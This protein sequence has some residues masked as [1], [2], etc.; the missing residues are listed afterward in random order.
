MTQ[1]RQPEPRDG[2]TTGS[3]AAA[4]T[5]A[6]LAVL[7]AGEMSDE[8]TIPLP[9]DEHGVIPPERITVPLS[10]CERV[11][12]RNALMGYAGVIKN[13]GD[14]PDVTDGLLITAHVARDP[15]QFPPE[16]LRDSRAPLALGNGITLYAGRG[17]GVATLPGLPV[18]VGEIAVNPSPRRQIAASLL[19]VAG[20][21]GYH[22]NIHCRLSALDGETRAKKTLNPRLGIVGGISILGTRGTVKAFSAEAWRV[23]ISRALD[24]AA[25]SGCSTVCLSTG[26][27]SE[28]ALRAMF[29]DLPE[30]AFIQAADHAGHALASAAARGFSRIVWGCFPG[31]LLKLAQGL[32]WTHAHAATPDFGLLEQLCA[33]VG[34]KGKSIRDAL[35]IPTVAGALETIRTLSPEGYRA[36]LARMAEMALASARALAAKGGRPGEIVVCAFAAHGELQATAKG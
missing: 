3:A 21:W 19:E 8:I 9:P 35:R 18:A 4:T 26:R 32:A 2:F 5:A 10:F 36:I 16:L 20:L 12:D 30:Q 17:I 23:T 25:E 29:S 15:A 11:T 22:G 6:A 14:D 7:L 33:E 28:K 24:V 34:L 31:K 27:R 13:A 1:S